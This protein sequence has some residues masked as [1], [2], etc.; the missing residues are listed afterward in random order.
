M[1]DYRVFFCIWSAAVI[2][3]CC[4][5][6]LDGFSPELITALAIVALLGS[7][8]YN[9][10]WRL[11]VFL[12]VWFSGA[13]SLMS[14]AT[15]LP[16]T[17]LAA[18]CLWAMV[19]TSPVLSLPF[20]GFRKPMPVT[21][22]IFVTGC[23]SGM[24]FWTAALLADIGYTVFAGCYLDD[25][26]AKLKAQ[27]ASPEAAEKR[28]TCVKLDVTDDK[29]VAAA[30]AVVKAQKVP[31]VGIINCAGVGFNGPGEYFPMAT[32]KRQMDVNFFGYVRVVQALMPLLR[33]GVERADRR[34]RVVF[35]GT[36]GGVFSPAPPLLSAYMA[37][38]WAIEAFCGSFR[39]EMQLKSLP[40]DACVLNPG[41]VKPTQLM[42]IGLKMKDKMWKDCKELNGGSNI[43]EDEYGAML[44]TFIEFS[45][46]E[47]GTH[48]SEVAKT[49][50]QIMAAHRPN[51]MYKVG[52][53]SKATPVVG[54]LPTAI[55]EFIV[56][57]QVYNM[58][59][60]T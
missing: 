39:F 17:Y 38:K 7:I 20:F 48:V 18:F 44:Q 34:G 33:T 21:G 54:L 40:I 10:L 56:K 14:P 13:I 5:S 9:W 15:P 4:G 36:G 59:G 35:I 23:D 26:E 60:S 19:H 46:K 50:A 11:I 12:L 2:A 42:E 43:A 3:Q 55:K 45:G 29:S 22:A 52:P 31:L 53:D 1:V 28:L 57:K 49:M 25:S 58:I 32:Y 16:A 51:A 41:F 30:T 6:T 47:E 37:S 24:G 8:F 27:C